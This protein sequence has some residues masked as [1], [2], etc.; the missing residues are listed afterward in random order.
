M[1]PWRKS[2]RSKRPVE[3][4]LS[5]V[6]SGILSELRDMADDKGVIATPKKDAVATV[7][8]M[9]GA[10]RGERRIVKRA[11]EELA[12]V[13]LIF[14][15]DQALYVSSSDPKA[16]LDWSFIDTQR[17]L[18]GTDATLTEHSCDIE[19]STKSTESFNTG[20]TDK[21]RKDKKRQDKTRTL[22]SSSGDGRV[23]EV[24]DYWISVMGKPASVKLNS[25]RRRAVQA[26]FKEGY[27]VEDIKRA[28]DGCR[29]SAWHMGDNDRKK[30]FNDLELICR[31]G[32]R[33]E[34]F[35]E[36]PVKSDSVIDEWANVSSNVHEIFGGAAR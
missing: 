19:T 26:R 4:A 31:D 29:A 24:F 11:I 20:S 10:S 17:A 32:T 8:M 12:E 23:S 2:F 15:T 25:K 36:R 6:V 14:V 13:G 27:S 9:R 34:G 22:S 16:T 21:T 7:I 35:A 30:P 28:I 5:I 18:V 33:L 1:N 3:M